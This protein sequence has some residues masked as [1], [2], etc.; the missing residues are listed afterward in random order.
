MKRQLLPRVLVVTPNIPEAQL[1]S[2]V[3]INNKDDI[4]TAAEA[5]M[6]FGAKYVLIKGGHLEGEPTDIL[7]DGSTVH[8]FTGRRI[9]GKNVHG[10]GCIFSSALVSRIALGDSVFDAVHFAKNF[11]FQAIEKSVRLGKG[12]M[13]FFPGFCING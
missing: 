6:K 13:D 3:K 4:K 10:T 9:E 7:F 1:L 12:K 8:E 5:I 11:T 2:G